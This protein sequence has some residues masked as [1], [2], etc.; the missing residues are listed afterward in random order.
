MIELLNRKLRN[1]IYRVYFYGTQCSPVTEISSTQVDISLFAT[2]A[3]PLQLYHSQGQFSGLILSHSQGQNLGLDQWFRKTGGQK[4]F[5]LH[6]VNLYCTR[7]SKMPTVRNAPH[8]LQVESCRAG[9]K[10][11]GKA[12]WMHC[13]QWTLTQTARLKRAST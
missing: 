1:T 12:R 4:Q 10:S 8:W 6:N 2:N 5:V 13:S 7:Y 11:G 9:F 3:N